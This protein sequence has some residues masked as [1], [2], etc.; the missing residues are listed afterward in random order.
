ME[1]FYIKSIVVIAP[2]LLQ[3]CSSTPG[4]PPSRACLLTGPN[5]WQLKEAGNHVPFFP[6]ATGSRNKLIE[7]ILCN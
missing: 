3:K 4:P 5:S 6:S 2:F 7:F 1:N